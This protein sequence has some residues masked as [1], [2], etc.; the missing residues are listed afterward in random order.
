MITANNTLRHHYESSGNQELSRRKLM[1]LP[2]ACNSLGG[3][4]VSLLLLAK[5]F[6]QCG[7]SEHLI[8]I[9]RSGS[10]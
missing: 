8:I 10:L 7:A 1:V 5:G 4:L 6:E 2:G 3:T 9:V